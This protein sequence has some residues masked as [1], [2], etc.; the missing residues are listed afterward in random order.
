[1]GI[2]PTISP[3]HQNYTSHQPHPWPIWGLIQQSPIHTRTTPKT[4]CSSPDNLLL[5]HEVES[6]KETCTINISKHQS[7]AYPWLW[8]YCWA[9]QSMKEIYT[10]DISK[11]Q[12]LPLTLILLLG[13]SGFQKGLATGLINLSYSKTYFKEKDFLINLYTNH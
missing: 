6:M 3:S 10:I 13:S 1:M 11:H 4:P 2:N 12:S 5:N 8:Y 7:K 9:H